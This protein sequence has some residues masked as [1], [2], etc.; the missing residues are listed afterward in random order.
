MVELTRAYRTGPHFPSQ[1][2]LGVGRTTNVLARRDNYAIAVILLL[3]FCVPFIQLGLSYE[4]S[5]Q[6]LAYAAVL[7]TV[8]KRLT[9]MEWCIWAFVYAAMLLGLFYYLDAEALFTA[10]LRVSREAL[11]ILLV[12]CAARNASWRVPAAFLSFMLQSVV[13]GLFLITLLQ[14]VSYTFLKRPQF[15]VPASF[16]IAG[17]DTIASRWLEVGRLNGFLANIRVSATYSEPSYL[18]FVCLCLAMIIHRAAFST[19][20]TLFLLAILFCTVCLCKSAS[21]VMLFVLLIAY[22]YRSIVF[23]PTRMVLFIAV[24]LLI[25]SI[26]A[27]VFDFNPVQRI[28]ESADPKLEPSGHI[29]LVMPWKHVATVLTESPL[30]VPWSELYSFFVQRADEYGAIGPVDK[31]TR[32]LVGQDNGFLNFFIEF[33][34]AGFVVIAGIVAVVRDRLNLLFLLA[35]TQFNGAPFGPDK[36][37]L[38]CFALSCRSSG[39]GERNR[40]SEAAET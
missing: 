34:W 9:M 39:G 40:T 7:L 37:A 20:K 8:R 6:Y 18:S 1:P 19:R 4:W 2:D 27:V 11:G 30:G 26:T 16:F 15:F 38:M 10:I 12:M 17:E 33:G 28:M 22:A 23:I 13:F 36:V 5:F 24:L 21:G 29:R 25:T 14:F 31:S 3:F 35:I 32:I